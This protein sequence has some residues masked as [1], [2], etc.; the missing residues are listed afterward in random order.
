MKT[1][2]NNQIY[3]VATTTIT[4]LIFGCI[5]NK[6]QSRN[7]IIAT[8]IILLI[9]L[10]FLFLSRKKIKILCIKDFKHGEK[11]K[12]KYLHRDTINTPYLSYARETKGSRRMVHQIAVS[13]EEYNILLEIQ[14][15]TKFIKFDNHLT[16]EEIK[17]GYISYPIK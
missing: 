11:V 14:K 4:F 17:I 9:V 7:N 6:D 3:I 12:I 8:A 16:T 13:E 15:E 5:I 1:L 2:K 10:I